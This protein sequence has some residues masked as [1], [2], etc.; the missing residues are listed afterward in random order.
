MRI[1]VVLRDLRCRTSGSVYANFS[2]IIWPHFELYTRAQARINFAFSS[3]FAEL[4]L[5]CE[6]IQDDDIKTFVFNNFSN[7]VKFGNILIDYVGR[8][9]DMY[10]TIVHL[11]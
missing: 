10:N 2:C 3:E 6:E 8:H 4:L 11:D 9:T 5:N 1:L 7:C